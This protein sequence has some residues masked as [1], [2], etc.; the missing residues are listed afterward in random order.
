MLKLCEDSID[1]CQILLLESVFLDFI[2][3]L[4]IIVN[5]SKLFSLHHY[6]ICLFSLRQISIIKQFMCRVIWTTLL[7]QTTQSFSLF[8]FHR[9]FTLHLIYKIKKLA[10]WTPFP[11]NKRDECWDQFIS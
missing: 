4:I 11:S 6:I 2:V 3:S 9:S 10:I 7:F 5:C 8:Y 1:V